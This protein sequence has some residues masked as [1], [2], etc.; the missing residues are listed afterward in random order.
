VAEAFEI[1][2][3]MVKAFWRGRHAGL[4][5][6]EPDWAC[7]VRGLREARPLIVAQAL[8]SAAGELS[9]QAGTSWNFGDVVIWLQRRAEELERRTGRG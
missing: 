6:G 5:L 1:T 2:D 4:P 7:T 3:E 8:R 9:A